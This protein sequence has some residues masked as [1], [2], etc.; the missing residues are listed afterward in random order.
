MAG[1]S[2]GLCDIW[3]GRG[4]WGCGIRNPGSFVTG[5]LQGLGG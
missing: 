3:S 4:S 2:F 1:G 5:V